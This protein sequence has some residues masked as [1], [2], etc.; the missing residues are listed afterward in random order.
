MPPVSRNAPC[1]CGSGR[2]HKLCCG[3]TREQERATRRAFEALFVLPV[4]FPLLRPDSDDFEEWLTAQ[5]AESP[6]RALVEDAVQR[7][8]LPERARISRSYARWFPQAWGSLVACV[9]DEAAAETA[10]LIGAVAAALAEERLPDEFVLE[11]LE[12]DPEPAEP[13]EALA[14]SLEASDLWS[15]AEA[16]AADRVVAAIPDDDEDE[17]ERRWD[18]DLQREAA[19]LLTRRHRR[20]LWLLVRRLHRELPIAGFPRASDA[21]AGACAAFERDRRVRARLA[22]TLLGDTLGPLLWQQRRLAA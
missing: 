19:R 8:P 13:V 1:P 2:K 18:A 21:I 17:Y 10:V 16:I 4:S 22:A 12:D 6:T 11:L 3:T 20:R 5:R 14:L 15:V 9:R 7:L